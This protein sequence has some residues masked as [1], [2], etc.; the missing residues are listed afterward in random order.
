MTTELTR[1]DAEAIKKRKRPVMEEPI[2]TG[3]PEVLSFDDSLRNIFPTLFDLPDTEVSSVLDTLE[4]F[5]REDTETFLQNVFERGNPA[6]AKQLF[7][8]LGLE[9]EDVTVDEAVSSMFGEVL[10]EEELERAVLSVFPDLTPDDFVQLVTEDFDEFIETITEGGPS[11]EKD[12][13]LQGLGFSEEDREDIFK[14]WFER[15]PEEGTDF[16]MELAGIRTLVH[17]DPK[18]LKVSAKGIDIGEF[19]IGGEFLVLEKGMSEYLNEHYIPPPQPSKDEI[20]KDYKKLVI[21][22]DKEFAD[23]ADWTIDGWRERRAANPERLQEWLDAQAK[24][25]D[26]YIQRSK[27]PAERVFSAGVGDVIA[28]AGGVARWM[29]EDGIGDRLSKFAEELQIQAPPDYLGEFDWG[30]IF[31]PRFY[32]TRVLRSLPFTLSLAPAAIIGAYASTHIPVVSPFIIK[33]IGKYGE[34]ILG[35]IGAAGLSRP[36]ESAFEAGTTYDEVF[37]RTGSKAQADKAAQK[38]FLG[39]LV[40]GGWDA[41]QF[42]LAFIPIKGVPASSRFWKLA[43]TGGKLAIVGLTE[44][45]EELYQETLQRWARGD[46]FE[47]DAE[48]QQVMA[49]GGIF[50]IGLGGVGDVF[51]R[52]KGQTLQNLTPDART[53]FEDDV[54]KFKAEGQTQEQ[55][56]LSA[57]DELAKTV[58]GGIATSDA[59]ETI[60]NE[61]FGRETQRQQEI[62]DERAVPAVPKVEPTVEAPVV[63]EVTIPEST[64]LDSEIATPATNLQETA[65]PEVVNETVPETADDNVVV[66]DVSVIDRFR[67]SRFVFEKMGLTNIWQSTF[68]A[69]TLLREEHTRFAKE[70]NKHAKNVGKDTLRRE[71]I[72]EFVNNSNQEVFNQLTFEE[73]QAA[74]WWKRT[75]DDWA[76]RLN[77]PQERRIKNYIP[78]IFDEQARRMGDIPLDASIAMILSK[79]I[80]D[81]VN[82]P[83]LKKRLGKEI[84]LVKDPFLAAQAYENMALR[85]F[86]YEPILQKLKLVS[87]HE[88]T[89]EFAGNYLKEYSKRM[90]GEVANIDREINAFLKDVAGNLRGLPGGERLAN[91][92]DKGNPSGMAAY[93][94]TSALYVMWLGFKPTSAI[95]NLSQHGLIIAE[96]DSIQDFANGIRLRF[97]AEGKLALSESLVVR[98]RRGAFIES[99]DSSVIEGLPAQFRELALFLFRLADEQNVKDAFLSGYAE[100]KRLYPEAGRNLWLKRGNEVAS[101]TQ[102]LYTKMNSLAIAQSGPGKVGAMLTTW[103]IN[104]LELM[105]RFVRGKQS[106]VY[107][108]LVKTSEGKFALKEK[109][110][111]QSRKSLLAY[112]AIVGLAYG[113]TLQD[114]NRL[115]AFEYS[116]FTSIRTFANLVGGEFP[117]L[118][119]PGAVAD[120]I[121]GTF[122]GDERQVKTGWN[123][124]KGAFSILNQLD[125]VASGEKDWLNLLFYLEG[126]DHQVRKLK[127]DWEKNWEPYDDLSDQII[128]SKEFPTLSLNAAQKKWREQNPEIEAQMFVTNRLG[129]LSSDEARTEVLR[130][131][132]KHNIDIEVINGYEKIFGVDTTEELDKFQKRIGS[133]EKLTIGKEAKYFTTGTF[134]SELNTIVKV[135]GRSKVERDGHEFSIFALGEQDSWQ[136][137]ED[138]DPTTGARLLYRQQNPDVE[139]SLY[140]FGK[141]RDFQNP[142]SA[143]ILLDWMDKYN[144]PPQAVLAFNENPDRYDELFTQKFE[145]EQKNFDL[146]TEYDNFGNMEASN[147]IEDSEERRLAREKFKADNPEWVADMRRIEAIDNDASNV[148]IEKWVDRGVAID[149]FG[150][151]SSQAKVWLIDNPETH[152]WALDSELLTETS[153]GWNVPVLRINVKWAKEDDFYN[154]G[155]PDKHKG[156]ENRDERDALVADER[157]R[158]LLN[159]PEYNRD[160]YRRDARSLVDDEFNRFPEESIET[161]VN[162]YII[163]KKPDDWL[164]GVAY[165]EDDWFLI[166]NPEFH[167]SLVGFGKFKELRDLRLVPTRAIFKKWWVYNTLTTQKDRDT[168]RLENPD[169]DEW[170]TQRKPDG[171]VFIWKTTMTE[172]RRRRRITPTERFLEDVSKIESEFDVKQKEIDELIKGLR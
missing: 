35:S 47:L 52:L 137:Y 129:T 74:N 37:T 1:R 105:N 148:I 134:L 103:A 81:K 80:S 83:F 96:V 90:T 82:A 84:G 122:L 50:G 117:G 120:I 154:I 164:E 58:E 63:E 69:E 8:T 91:F 55:A 27:S 61:G 3:I 161:Y 19:T 43:M 36:L 162:Y 133:L 62:I 94:L 28:T 116:G 146:T 109:N 75:A 144:I 104:W 66:H 130:L 54:T 89:P 6:T 65:Q 16:V 172:Q 30:M 126:K 68:E 88:T 108:D 141:I 92:L 33:H 145:L 73:K 59:I 48:M 106:Q 76:N 93:N 23:V 124:I 7:E 70:L 123:K 71:L 135:N 159:N 142:E 38:V 121:S 31:N 136:P 97:T 101:N 85:I 169:L 79:K 165:Y 152:T 149:E 139:A 151:S 128:R 102:Y 5:A 26:D 24:A 157:E 56:E 110:W 20:E 95:R 118:Q 171:K 67:P 107:I 14:P 163:P 34:L 9:F 51:T 10:D 17:I 147:F 114:W 13:I 138:Y 21:D 140:L 22:I 119:L 4:I 72:W 143:K 41:A 113:L 40:L 115:K 87:E 57:F 11:L 78:H 46:E 86:Y 49:I 166:D 153:D 2:G 60:K 100:A 29:G 112:M 53:V 12:I 131:I 170:G 155:I 127:E 25:W 42:A 77:I 150:S 156:T 15:L 160:R 111:L 44:A 64:P 99:I 168:Y 45:G 132:D 98:S 39:N 167:Q 158:Y 18:N 125:D 32:S